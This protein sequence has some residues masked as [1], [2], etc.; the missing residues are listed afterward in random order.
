MC[1]CALMHACVCM[2]VYACVCACACAC[3]CA[4]ERERMHEKGNTGKIGNKTCNLLNKFLLML[5]CSIA[6]KVKLKVEEQLLVVRHLT[7]F[8][9][10]WAIGSQVPNL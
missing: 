9:P 8:D 1:V 7:V 3:A 4:R 5:C 2:C 10:Y 6:M